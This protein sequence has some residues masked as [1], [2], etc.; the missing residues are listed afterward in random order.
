VAVTFVP[1]VMDESEGMADDV[2]ADPRMVAD[3]WIDHGDRDV[4][5]VTEALHAAEPRHLHDAHTMGPVCIFCA[6]R[7]TLAVRAVHDAHR[8]DGRGGGPGGGTGGWD[9]QG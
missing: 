2:W 6:R 3:P 8:Y 5:R 4:H 7:A 1:P 9:R